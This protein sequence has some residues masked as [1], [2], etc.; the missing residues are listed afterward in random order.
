MLI[1]RRRAA[2]QR[3]SAG[4]CARL[5]MWRASQRRAMPGPARAP[6]PNS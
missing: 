3:R 2:G 5:W 1:C 6:G 4:V